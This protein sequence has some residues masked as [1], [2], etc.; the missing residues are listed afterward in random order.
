M[1]FEIQTE[2]VV[3]RTGGKNTEKLPRKFGPEHNKFLHKGSKGRPA[4]GTKKAQRSSC[5]PRRAASWSS[6]RRPGTV[7][8]AT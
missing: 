2:N 1:K 4:K 6:K 5:S 7:I 3:W 8:G